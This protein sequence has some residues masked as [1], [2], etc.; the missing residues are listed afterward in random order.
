MP[1]EHIVANDAKLFQSFAGNAVRRDERLKM[2]EPR[3]AIIIDAEKSGSLVPPSAEKCI[4][5][6]TVEGMMRNFREQMIPK[7]EFL[8]CLERSPVFRNA[9]FRLRAE[10]LFCAG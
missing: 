10:N 8:E 9:D 4:Q 6:K 2:V 1:L 7:R 3:A 5:H